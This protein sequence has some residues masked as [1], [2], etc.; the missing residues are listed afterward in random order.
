MKK[1]LASFPLQTFYCTC[2]QFWSK[3]FFALTGKNIAVKSATKIRDVAQSG[4][5]P[6]WGSGGREFKSRRP[7]Q[8]FDGK[9]SQESPVLLFHLKSIS[10]LSAW[11]MCGA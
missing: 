1:R 7:D 11:P 4:S 6:E 3:R 9:S 8:F 5:A 2:K 10:Y